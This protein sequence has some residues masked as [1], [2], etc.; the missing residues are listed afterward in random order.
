MRY[1]DLRIGMRAKLIKSTFNG[2][3]SFSHS[4]N[5][6]SNNFAPHIGKIGTIKSLDGRSVGMVFENFSI[7]TICP[8][9]LELQQMDVELVI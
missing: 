3:C 2:E 8:C 7:G 4:Y 9:E 5:T 1:N 6:S